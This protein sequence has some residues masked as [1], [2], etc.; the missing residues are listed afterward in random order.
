MEEQNAL[1][2]K[3]RCILALIFSTGL[4]DLGRSRSIGF[5]GT[6]SSSSEILQHNTIIMLV[7]LLL[8]IQDR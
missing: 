7:L 2:F 1:L 8:N 4:H 3:E 6:D 5:D